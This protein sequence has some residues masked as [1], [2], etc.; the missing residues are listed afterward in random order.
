MAKARSFGCLGVDVNGG[1]FQRT[2]GW[3]RVTAFYAVV[4]VY[5]TGGVPGKE[6][7]MTRGSRRFGDDYFKDLVKGIHET[8]GREGWWG[9]TS[10]LY[11]IAPR[12]AHLTPME[13]FRPWIFSMPK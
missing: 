3:Y 12:V 1:A 7:I 8:C 6:R 4:V 11:E 13:A 9:L 2:D 5:F 10:G